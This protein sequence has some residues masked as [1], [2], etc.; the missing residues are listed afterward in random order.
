MR[1]TPLYR[2]ASGHRFVAGPVA[3]SIGLPVDCSEG[4]SVCLRVDPSWPMNPDV[5]EDSISLDLS[6]AG[7]VSRYTI[8]LSCIC[9]IMEVSN[10]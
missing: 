8:P 10:G 2:C 4:R 9:K 1:P 6:F 5:A 3:E 7:N